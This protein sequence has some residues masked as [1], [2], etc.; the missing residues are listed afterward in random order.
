MSEY[1]PLI[2]IITVVYNG[3]ETLEKTIQTVINQTY[4]NIQYIIIDGG[5]VDGTVSV[6][7]RYKSKI[8]YWISEPDGGIF[9]AMNKGL[10]KA[11]GEWVI[12]MNAGDGFYNEHILASIF[13][14]PIKSDVELIYG[15]VYL[16]DHNDGYLVESRTN[17]FKINLNAICHQ[18]VFIK[19]SLHRLFEIKY[20]LS[21]DHDLIYDF[22][23]R[24]HC[25]YLNMPI[26]RI[27][28]GGVSSNL[29]GTRKEKFIITLSRGNVIDIVLA[30]S[31]Y[32]YGIIK[33]YTKKILILIFP[34]RVF[35]SI[36]SLKNKLE[37]F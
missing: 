10:S 36:R 4:A 22:V 33:E 25:L 37:Q 1:P 18:S 32:L 14:E 6:I 29:K 13:N 5:S 11:S 28:M 19:R 16:Y 31:F 35:A 27:L 15:D 30:F 17:K 23:K 20:K 3:F 2:S 26:S 9:D 8:N 12:F 24:G 21:A 7:S 34:F